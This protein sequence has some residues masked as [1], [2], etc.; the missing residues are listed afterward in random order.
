M[1]VGLHLGASL[2]RPS[3]QA[4]LL[5]LKSPE[6][7]PPKGPELA[8][9][10]WLSSGPLEG[11]KSGGVQASALGKNSRGSQLARG[12]PATHTHR[13]DTQAHG[14]TFKPGSKVL[15]K[16]ILLSPLHR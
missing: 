8:R 10:W 3:R 15:F 13:Q 7:C 9:P 5:E 14:Q 1:K 12:P 2:A 6:L 16:S 4:A 11:G